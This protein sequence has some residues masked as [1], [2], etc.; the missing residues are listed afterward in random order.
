MA[1]N[2]ARA[3]KMTAASSEGTVVEYTLGE[4]VKGVMARLSA[5]DQ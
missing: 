1:L 4:G 3:G 5:V 2:K